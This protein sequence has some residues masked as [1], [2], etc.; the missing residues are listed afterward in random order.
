MSQFYDEMAQLVIDMLDVYGVD[1][2]IKRT[3]GNHATD[4]PIR[5]IFTNPQQYVIP[6]PQSPPPDARLVM[7][8][9]TE[10]KRTDS[11]SFG[12]KRY[13]II[14]VRTMQPADK[15]LGYRVDLRLS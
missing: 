9:K 15:V 8:N 12:G 14:L 1:L 2:I 4:L 10:P 13:T 11:I 6:D 5:A 7:N 3:V